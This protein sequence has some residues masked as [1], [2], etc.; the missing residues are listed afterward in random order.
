MVNRILITM[1]FIISLLSS[2]INM[3]EPGSQAEY[4]NCRN[5]YDSILV[6]HLPKKLPNNSNGFSFSSIDNIIE[7][8]YA[9]ID[10]KVQ[11]NN[12]KKYQK[13]KEQLLKHAKYIKK[14][15][16]SNLVIIPSID[17]FAKKNID[18]TKLKSFLHIPKNA[19][20]EIDLTTYKY[21][22]IKNLDII[23]LDYGLN[24]VLNHKKMERKDL[25]KGCLNGFS[26]G[27]TTNDS[28]LTIQYWLLIW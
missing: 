4:I 22:L 23:I 8:G 3:N 25:P 21:H 17:E 27:V 11:I 7:D 15:Q 1:F 12:K 26:K 18:S 10:I 28:M 24:D 5:S 13:I 6:N 9:G 16:D 19:I 2:C 20:Y 14:S